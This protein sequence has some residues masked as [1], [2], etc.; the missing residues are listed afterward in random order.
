MLQYFLK[1]LLAIIPKLLIVSMLI[2]F[3]MDLLPVDPVAQAMPREAYENMSREQ[4]EAKREELGLNDPAIVR[5]FRWLGNILQGD[6]GYSHVSG[7]SVTRLVKERLPATIELNA[8]ALLFST[9][10]GLTMGIIS[11][12]NR[13]KLVD[14]TN[15]AF[16]LLCQSIP[17]IFIA[18]VMILVFSLK[19][20]WLP[21]GGRTNVGVTTYWGRIPYMVMPVCVACLGLIANLLRITRSSMLD[22]MGKDYIKTARAKGATEGVIFGK[23]I[24][25]N[26]AIPVA[27]LLVMR[28]PDLFGGSVIIENLFSYP[29]I[30]SL[31]TEALG[32]ND[33]PVCMVTMLLSTTIFMMFTLISDLAIAALDPRV[34]FGKEG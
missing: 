17:S 18:L 23:H 13:G 4:L 8:W 28:I 3:G 27:M 1:R 33:V 15:T 34:R 26:G 22:V 19:L 21:G 12:K 29:G 31:A 7:T 32:Q 16:A 11:S 2:F 24:F 14:Y 6:F 20:K 9:I 5:Y 25:R 30:G 10:I